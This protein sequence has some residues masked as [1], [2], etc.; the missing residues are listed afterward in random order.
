MLIGSDS[1][2]NRYCGVDLVKQ[3][4][5]SANNSLGCRMYNPEIRTL[6]HS[7]TFQKL[8]STLPRI[9]HLL[10]CMFLRL[11]DQF[12]AEDIWNKQ[13]RPFASLLFI[14]K[15]QV[16]NASC[17]QSKHSFRHEQTICFSG[18]WNTTRLVFIHPSNSKF[19]SMFGVANSCEV[20]D[21]IYSTITDASDAL[22]TFLSRPWTREFL[23]LSAPAK[24]R[25]IAEFEALIKATGNLHSPCPI[26]DSIK[27]HCVKRKLPIQMPK[28][29]KTAVT[30]AD[31]YFT[32]LKY[33]VNPGLLSHHMPDGDEDEEPT[34]FSISFEDAVLKYRG[35]IIQKKLRIPRFF[36]MAKAVAEFYISKSLISRNYEPSAF[37]AQQ[38]RHTMRNQSTSISQDSR[39]ID[40]C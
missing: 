32:G 24:T 7:Q 16:S 30:F 38:S 10:N 17:Y 20:G 33:G 6:F 3:S 1:N 23:Y 15:T 25:V 26:Y 2:P 31:Q 35:D 5:L 19:C 39:N 14:I 29:R 22:Y 21:F 28:F 40:I 36:A 34:F 18:Q 37:S 8:K 4:G 11:V 27:I 12:D 9:R 13:I